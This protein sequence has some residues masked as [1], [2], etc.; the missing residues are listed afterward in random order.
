MMMHAEKVYEYPILAVGVLLVGLSIIG[1]IVVEL[2]VRRFLAIDLRR[3]HND[4]AA[5]VFSVIGV[6]FAVLL[7]FVVMLT[8]E[9]YQS[10][11]TAA[12]S[13]AM[14]VRDVAD[15]AAG[16]AEPTRS[17]LRN[18][19]SSYLRE[20]IDREWPAQ[21][22]GRF[23]DSAAGSLRE[24]DAFA[25]GYHAVGPIDTN[26]HAALLSA[27]TRM[28]DARAVR[29]LA[30]SN[31]VPPIVWVVMLLGGS[32]TVASAS[33]LGAPSLGMQLTMSATLSASGAMVVVLI[34]ALSQPFRGD[35]RVSTGSFE[36]VLAS[37][38]SDAPKPRP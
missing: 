3:Q 32:L 34:I 14:V 23:D 28:Q 12:G 36:R 22:A 35:F 6:T 20:V 1:A 15:A 8:F 30:A 25:A 11:R 33:F 29:Q 4:V 17:H 10:A 31:I 38:R 16:L 37:I 19:L 18:G 5:A 27:L 7:A 9:G 2:V 24:L 13:E 26:Y 21:S